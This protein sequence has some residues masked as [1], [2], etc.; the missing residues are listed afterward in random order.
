MVI[1]IILIK[2]AIMMTIMIIMIFNTILKVKVFFFNCHGLK[3]R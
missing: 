3:V 2:V 1:V